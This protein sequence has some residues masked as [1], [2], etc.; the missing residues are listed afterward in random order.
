MG[1]IDQNQHPKPS[2]IDCIPSS[3]HHHN[4]NHHHSH[5]SHHNHT[6]THTHPTDLEVF[7]FAI[8]PYILSRFIWSILR[9]YQEHPYASTPHSDEPDI[10][11]AYAAFLDMWPV[12]PGR[13]RYVADG[14]A[15]C[16][17]AGGVLDT[18]EKKEF[19][20]VHRKGVE[21]V[22]G[23]LRSCVLGNRAKVDMEGILTCLMFVERTL[24]SCVGR[25]EEGKTLVEGYC[26]GGSGGAGCELDISNVEVEWLFLAGLMMVYKVREDYPPAPF[27][28]AFVACGGG[29]NEAGFDHVETSPSTS[30]A[31]I[32]NG[33]TALSA[34]HL[35][36]DQDL[37]NEDDKDSVAADDAD[38][39]MPGEVFHMSPE[40]PCSAGTTPLQQQPQEAE[41][42]ACRQCRDLADD[43]I[44][45]ERVMLKA[46]GYHCFV[47]KEEYGE[48]RELVKVFARVWDDRI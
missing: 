20:R 21:V 19:V 12:S 38:S 25:F 27:E 36:F 6:H 23:V 9:F 26:L 11:V 15:Y 41:D 24:R 30:V 29:E 17:D 45:I 34:D 46:L 44:G 10:G 39:R 8:D 47:G 5:H 43:L 40:A 37:D 3:Y 18:R 16:C 32:G 31:N 48:F 28:W 13:I 33:I 14:C 35:H 4:H 22:H 1:S 2:L 42:L 7:T